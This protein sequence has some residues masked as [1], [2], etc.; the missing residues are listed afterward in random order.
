MLAATGFLFRSL[1]THALL[2]P[3]ASILRERIT[4]G[5]CC[6]ADGYHL[7]P[8][9][10]TAKSLSPGCFGSSWTP[11]SSAGVDFFDTRQGRLNCN[12]WETWLRHFN[13]EMAASCRHTALLVGCTLPSGTLE[14]AEPF[15][16]SGING[17]TLSH[18]T[19]FRFPVGCSRAVQPAAQGLIASFRARIRRRQLLWHLEQMSHDS[20]VLPPRASIRQAI[21]W[22]AAAWMEMN[23]S[24]VQECWHR[25]NLLDLP[26]SSLGSQ[27]SHQY[28]WQQ[29]FNSQGSHVTAFVD[30]EVLGDLSAALELLAQKT[31]NL[32]VGSSL[33]QIGELLSIPQEDEVQEELPGLDL[34]GS[35]NSPVH[36]MDGANDEVD[37]ADRRPPVSIS[38]DE[39]LAAAQ[40]ISR[41][42]GDNIAL[43]KEDGSELRNSANQMVL[44]LQ[45]AMVRANSVL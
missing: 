19:V 23:P 38:I 37:D 18:T 21:E 13:S 2:H 14:E 31:C 22:S 12:V 40:V 43:F 33:L 11:E 7:R 24:T 6:S 26:A 42:V 45:Q 35:Q 27:R 39:A 20:A 4:I 3:G 8:L 36:G 28:P 29:Q 16:A 9:V 5:L 17:F 15:E 32:V 34:L 41:F 1:P 25:C 10:I 30:R 44:V